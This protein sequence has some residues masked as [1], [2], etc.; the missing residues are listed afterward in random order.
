MTQNYSEAFRRPIQELTLIKFVKE[1]F[2]NHVPFQMMISFSSDAYEER[3]REM[4]LS[5]IYLF[6]DSL[7]CVTGV[8]FQC[9]ENEIFDSEAL[10]CVYSFATPPTIPIDTS[11]LPQITTEDPVLDGICENLFFDFI[12]HPTDCGLLIFCYMQFPIIRE[13]PQGEI[14]DIQRTQ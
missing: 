14:F 7:H 10:R 11:S 12:E 3:V 6:F 1:S 2:L 13:C 8:I 4:S 9:F 5:L